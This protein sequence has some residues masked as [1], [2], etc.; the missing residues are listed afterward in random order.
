MVTEMKVNPEAAGFDA[1]RLARVEEH[2]RRRYIAPGKIAGCQLAIVRHG[3][4]AHHS[5]LGMR[6]L[7]RAVPVTDDTI[8]RLYS[9][10]KPITGVALLSLYEQ[11][12]FQLDDPVHRF[13]PSFRKMQVVERA[14]DGTKTLVDAK[15]PITMRHAMMHTTGI[16]YGPKGAQLDMAT[17]GKPGGHGLFGGGATLESVMDRLAAEPLRFHPGDQWLYSLSTD[18]CARLV[19]VISGQRFDE[20]L[21]ATIFEPLGMTSTSFHVPETEANRLAALYTRGPD[22]SLVLLDDP[23]KSAYR[24]EPTFLSGGGGLLGTTAD[25]LRFAQMLVN[26]GE[27]DG[28]RILSRKTVELM[29]ANHLPGGRDLAA[30]ASPGGYGETGFAG[31]GFGLTVAVSQ[32]PAESGAAGSRGEFMWGGA[33]STIFWIDPVEDLAVVFMTQLIPSGTFNFRG[34]LKSLVYGAIAD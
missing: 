22:K 24:R 29:S 1:D 5:V 3:Q 20:Y 32:G 16:G 23:A 12:L 14:S 11:G 21:R 25:Y 17:I 8:W 6:D 15:R 4:L 28:V 2:L 27:L 33:A 10:T 7:E 34:Q 13:I 26:R 30:F 18:L 19:E 31:M 9:M